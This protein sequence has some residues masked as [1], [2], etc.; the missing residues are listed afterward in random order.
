MHVTG[1]KIDPP[2]FNSVILLSGR[3][4][5]RLGSDRRPRYGLCS[6]QIWYRWAIVFAKV[7]NDMGKSFFADSNRWQ[8]LCHK[9]LD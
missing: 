9:D 7:I 2:E 6:S 1:G 3:F 4:S 8:I 5:L